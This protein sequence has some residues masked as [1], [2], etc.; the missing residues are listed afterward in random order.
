MIAHRRTRTPEQ[1]QADVRAGIAECLRYGTTLVGDIAA[2]GA[3]WDALAESA[4]R[5]VVFHELLGLTED[6]AARRRWRRGAG[7]R[8]TRGRRHAGQ[9]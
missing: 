6:R 2:G 4:L 9:D 5:A 7:W 1:T 8:H 3:S